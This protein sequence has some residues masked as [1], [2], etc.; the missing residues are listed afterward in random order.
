MSPISRP[1][2]LRDNVG[3]EDFDIPVPIHAALTDDSEVLSVTISGVPEG[4]S[5]SAGTYDPET[6]TWSVDP[7]DLEGL[8]VSPPPD[9]NE[10]FTLSVTATSTSEDG[11]I[12]TTTGDVFIEVIGVADRPDLETQ[13]VM[14]DEGVPIPLD[15]RIRFERYRRLRDADDRNFQR[16]AEGAV[17]AVDGVRA[18]AQRGRCVHLER[19]I[20]SDG[21]TVTSPAGHRWRLHAACRGEGDGG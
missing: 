15:I 21:V 11:D 3:Y 19:K 1:W 10:D 4:A 6:D 2:F 5:L 9:S 7:A 12:A 17:M 8:T 18:D 16:A 14:G 20:N 13:D